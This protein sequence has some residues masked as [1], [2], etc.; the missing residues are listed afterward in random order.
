MLGLVPVIVFLGGA[1]G[2]P[3]KWP[4]ENWAHNISVV[5]VILA[6]GAAIFWVGGVY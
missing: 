1:L 3:A 4:K 6:I 2:I 5:L